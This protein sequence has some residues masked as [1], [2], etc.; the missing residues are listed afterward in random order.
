M[1]TTTHRPTL[2]LRGITKRFGHVTALDDV[3]LQARPGEILA[4]LGDNGAG[5]STLVKV[6]S[7]LY[8][9]DEGEIR[10]AGDPRR[11]ATPAQARSAGIATVHQDLALVECLDV[12]T[13][14]FLGRFP[15]RGLF[16]DRARMERETEEF[17]RSLDVTVSSVR[18]EIG[19]LSGGQRQIVAIARALKT[20]ADTVLLDEP[21]AALGVRETAQAAD[22]I[23]RLRDQG[24]AVIVVSHDMQLVF[25]TADRVQVMRLGRVA[26]VRTVAETDRDEVVALI[27]GSRRDT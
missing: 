1:T 5:K 11:F 14:L 6:M 18:T 25:D 3:H 17:L 23:R 9:P 27:T 2:E 4:L 19:M 13:N 21:T 10:L 26:G 22:L 16:V 12:A 20:G 15:R 24:K 8:A 7:G